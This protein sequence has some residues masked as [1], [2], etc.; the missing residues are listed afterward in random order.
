MLEIQ[1]SQNTAIRGNVL[2]INIPPKVWRPK[3]I[4]RY[5]PTYNS[6]DID[7]GFFDYKCYGKAVFRP[8]FQWKDTDRQDLISYQED[9]DSE[10]LQ[11]YIKIREDASNEHKSTIINLVKTYWDCFCK[12]G[13][14]RHS[15]TSML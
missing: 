8:T 14:R 11:A 13:V 12:K 1:P 10:E 3:V 2:L 4:N 6:S 5:I 7:E 15:K 9:K